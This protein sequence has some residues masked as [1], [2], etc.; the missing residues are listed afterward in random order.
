MP[1]TKTVK[2]PKIE[3]L[4]SG[5]YHCHL[6]SHTD[7][8]GKRVYVSLTEQSLDALTRRV[9]DFKADKK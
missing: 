3:Q 4:P 6:Y 8:Q 7:D 2:L 5:S 9:L 1:R